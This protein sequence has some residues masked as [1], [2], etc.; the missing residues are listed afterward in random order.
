MAARGIAAQQTWSVKSNQILTV[1]YTRNILQE[2]LIK[3]H[4]EQESTECGTFS[5]HWPCIE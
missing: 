5:R 1:D 4:Y 2:N 3:Q